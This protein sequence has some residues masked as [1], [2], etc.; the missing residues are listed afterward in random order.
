VEAVAQL[1][2][3]C[4]TDTPGASRWIQRPIPTACMLN[5]SQW[6]VLDSRVLCAN[7]RL[8]RANY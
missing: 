1:L 3:V 2:L 7:V 4:Q 6:L 5:F 8:K